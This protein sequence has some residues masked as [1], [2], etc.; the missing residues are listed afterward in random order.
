MSFDIIFK[1]KVARFLELVGFE[2]SGE[3]AMDAPKKLL[4]GD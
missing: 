4:L 3:G 2:I 1:V